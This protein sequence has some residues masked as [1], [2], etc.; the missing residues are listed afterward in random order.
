VAVEQ[1]P[2]S[3]VSAS[4]DAKG[5]FVL[6]GVAPGRYMV[7]AEG[8][9]FAGASRESVAVGVLERAPELV[10]AMMRALQVRGRVLVG[11]K[12]VPCPE[13]RVSLKE[14]E[15]SLSSSFR[16]GSSPGSPSG[17]RSSTARGSPYRT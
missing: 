11:D 3:D 12:R 6:E 14:T 7:E 5:R 4:S 10:I 8:P 9:H 2:G 17:A 15:K 13:G 16:G 1:I